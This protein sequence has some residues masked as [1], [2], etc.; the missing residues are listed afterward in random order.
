[1]MSIVERDGRDLLLANLLLQSRGLVDEA[2]ERVLA[3]LDE[4]A[5]EVINKYMWAA[6][7]AAAI[8][9]FPLL[10]LAGG[11]AIT[12]KMVLDLAARVPAEDR[13]RHGRHAAR[14]AGQESDR[15]G[16]RD[17]RRRRR[18]RRRSARC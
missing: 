14:P 2:K 17:R 5:D 7:G 4:R 15:D 3:A 18:W 13:R 6:G 9:P 16:R 12:V 1:M 11:S 8:N 10:D